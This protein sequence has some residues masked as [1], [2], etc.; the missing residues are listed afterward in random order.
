[1]T[2]FEKMDQSWIPE[3]NLILCWMKVFRKADRF[4]SK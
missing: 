4:F 1:M 2:Q 3:S